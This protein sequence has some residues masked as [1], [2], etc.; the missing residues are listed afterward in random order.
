MNIFKLF[1]TMV[2]AFSAIT[3]SAAN[4]ADKNNQ[5]NNKISEQAYYKWEELYQICINE[6]DSCI[7]D[8][9]KDDGKKLKKLKMSEVEFNS[10]KDLC[11]KLKSSIVQLKT[12]SDF[13]TPIDFDINKWDSLSCKFKDVI[14]ND[15]KDLEK[16]SD[17]KWEEY[18]NNLKNYY[19]NLTESY[20]N[21]KF[22]YAEKLINENNDQKTKISQLKAQNDSLTKKLKG[23]ESELNKFKTDKTNFGNGLQRAFEVCVFFPL[24]VKCNK[25]YVSYAHLAAKE[26]IFSDKGN[27]VPEMWTDWR[28]YE[29]L[30]LNYGKYNDAFI[31]Y[32][33][34]QKTT[35]LAKPDKKITTEEVEFNK[36]VIE[37]TNDYPILKEYFTKYYNTDVSIS[38]LDNV[39]NQFFKELTK[40]TTNGKVLNDKFFNNFISIHLK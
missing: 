37:L 28:K 2:I 23:V 39:I 33:E 4:Q 13:N 6:Y 1:I 36:S 40:Y 24:A 10:Y 21:A 12:A 20:K 7:M 35:L 17:K 14:K 16:N 11:S 25:D 18:C 38:Y 31:K 32:I 26:M 34:E 27:I 8:A 22:N 9:K 19:S 3:I 5:Q 29:P 15:I 30:L